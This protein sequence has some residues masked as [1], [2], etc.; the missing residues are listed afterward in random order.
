MKAIGWSALIVGTIGTIYDLSQGSKVGIKLEKPKNTDVALEKKPI[1]I[2]SISSDTSLKE[3]WGETIKAE[4][5]DGVSGIGK[6]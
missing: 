2:C 1:A 5:N 4:A 6:R 3:N